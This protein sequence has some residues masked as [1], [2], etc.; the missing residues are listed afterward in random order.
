MKYQIL[1]ITVFLLAVSVSGSFLT[2]C[3]DDDGDPPANADVP[4]VLI[5]AGSFTMGDQHGDGQPNE[6]PA[7][8]VALDGF[9]MS[10]Y[11][12][13]Q[14]A[15]Q[16]VMGGNPSINRGDNK[17]VDNVTW[18]NALEFCNALSQRDGFEPCYTD[19]SGSLSLD[20]NAN[21]YR[22]P[23]EAE[24]EYA[25]KAG[26]ATSYYNG[27]GQ[28]D[29]SRAG[30][31]S[32]NAGGGTHDVGQREANSFGLCDMHGNVFEWCWDWYLPDYY[33]KGENL[34]PLG[35]QGGTE[36]VCRGGSYFVFEYGCRSTFRSTLK[37]TIPSRDIGFRVVRKAS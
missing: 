32:G 33:S 36:R 10:K 13:T 15:Y 6:K 20:V 17:P 9:Y 37:P 2:A 35:P 18:F 31:Y 12:I 29:L 28:A 27:N 14:K 19:I 8:T 24:W 1:R 30:W 34:N 26:T 11:E 23:T 25:C 5:P 3:S 16:S 21:G 22:L 7:R 4:M